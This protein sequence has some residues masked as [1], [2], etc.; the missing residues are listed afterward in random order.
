MRPRRSLATERVIR[1]IN[2]TFA[3]GANR[4]MPA[5]GTAIHGDGT[6]T[7]ATPNRMLELSGIA[8]TSHGNGTRLLIRAANIAP[9]SGPIDTVED[10]TDH[11]AGDTM[12]AQRDGDGKDDAGIREVDQRRLYRER[13]QHR[14]PPDVS[15]A[16]PNPPSQCVVVDRASPRSEV[17][18]HACE[19]DDREQVR[20][21]VRDERHGASHVEECTA[22]RWPADR[23]RLSPGLNGCPSR[24][25]L[26]VRKNSG[27]HGVGGCIQ[28]DATNR[29]DGSDDQHQRPPHVTRGDHC[30]ER[31]QASHPYDVAPD[32]QQT[33]VELVDH[34]TGWHAGGDTHRGRDRS[35][36]ACRRRRTG[37]GQDQ[38]RISER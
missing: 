24:L 17:A 23:G 25:Q 31:G 13:P 4:P 36:N 26:Q 27:H 29:V 12:D 9:T 8:V 37:Y 14:R 21:A 32:H 18:A 35:D 28:Y 19:A 6:N 5:S 16:L 3:A 10:P 20:D 33:P 22:Q 1:A 2:A 34:G 15:K 38:Q 11:P 30:G 7:A